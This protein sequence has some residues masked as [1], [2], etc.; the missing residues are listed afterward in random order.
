MKSK[1][2][3]LLAVVQLAVLMVS[4]TTASA[5]V[6][7][8]GEQ[9]FVDGSI[10]LLSAFGPA[11]TGEPAPFNAYNGSD[12]NGPNFSASWTFN[13]APGGYTAGSVVIGIYEHDSAFT[14]A[15]LASFVLDGIDLTADLSALMEARGGADKEYN[16]YEL[17]LSGIAL[18]QINDGIATFSMALQ[19]QA[20]YGDGLTAAYNGA[21]L[22]FSQL[23]LDV[24]EPGTLALLGL[25]LAGLGLSRRRK[26][27]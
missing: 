12:P 14:G 27:A 23:R 18:N 17:M 11:S 24:P 5:M 8:L 13:L 10:V 3:G 20:A 22:D 15:Q 21:G 2:R 19:G 7:T 9:D 26:A 16:I 25:G 1:V 4:S 6:V